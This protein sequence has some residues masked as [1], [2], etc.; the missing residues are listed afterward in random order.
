MESFGHFSSSFLFMQIST[1]RKLTSNYCPTEICVLEHE[2]LGSLGL[3]TKNFLA[4][5]QM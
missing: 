2:N 4:L 3:G 5:L 1:K